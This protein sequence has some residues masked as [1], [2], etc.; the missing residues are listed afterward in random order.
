MH[1]SKF[2]SI[3]GVPDEDQVQAWVESFFQNTTMVL[4]SFF[5]HV[6]AA[7]AVERMAL[8]PFAKLV[9]EQLDGENETVIQMAVEFINELAGIEL[10]CMRAYL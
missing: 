9:A 5:V 3:N 1:I 8:V 7:E 2:K 4:N 10:E 6:S